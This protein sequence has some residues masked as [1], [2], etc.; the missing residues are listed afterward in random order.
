MREVAR[1]R[2]P[3]TRTALTLFTDQPGVQVYTGNSLDGTLPSLHGRWYRQN[4]GI[5]LEPQLF[6]D[7]PNR[8]DFGS[9]VLRPGEQYQWHSS[10]R[11]DKVA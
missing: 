10:W 3:R 6:P 9:A 1:L 4:A 5:A 8:P 7:T 2:S 11:L